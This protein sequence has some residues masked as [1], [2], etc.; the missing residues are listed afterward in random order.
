V[1]VILYEMLTGNRPFCT[2]I[3]QQTIFRERLIETEA[4]LYVSSNK[5]SRRMNII[6]NKLLVYDQN[7]RPSIQEIVDNKMFGIN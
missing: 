5:V 2:D 3:D 4:K 7:K 6:L 1:G